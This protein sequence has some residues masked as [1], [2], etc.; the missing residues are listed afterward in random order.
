PLDHSVPHGRYRRGLSEHT[1]NPQSALLLAATVQSDRLT[2]YDFH[3][4]PKRYSQSGRPTGSAHQ[5][6]SMI[7]LF[8]AAF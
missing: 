5:E 7:A 4:D 2:A 6:Q 1:G 8:A 3:W